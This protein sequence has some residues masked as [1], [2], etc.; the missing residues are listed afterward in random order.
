MRVERDGIIR[1]RRWLEEH[2]Y[3]YRAI[4]RYSY[5]AIERYSYR[6]SRRSMVRDD[7]VDTRLLYYMPFIALLPTLLPALRWRSDQGQ[8]GS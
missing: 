1:A 2:L 4:E 5:R 7:Y 3:S 6:A 8:L